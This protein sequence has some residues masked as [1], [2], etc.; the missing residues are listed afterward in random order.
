VHGEFLKCR[1]WPVK[2]Y[3]LSISACIM[4]VLFSGVP[5]NVVRA[6][7]QLARAPTSCERVSMCV[8]LCMSA[9][10]CVCC[11]DD[12]VG[13]FEDLMWLLAVA[14][15]SGTACGVWRMPR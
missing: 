1:E 5:S 15:G 8:R 12:F 3:S 10:V 11:L 4:N 9:C 14:K 2:D 13:I 7:A 6:C